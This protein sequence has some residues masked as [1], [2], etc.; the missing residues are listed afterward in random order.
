MGRAPTPISK[1]EAQEMRRQYENGATLHELR[2]EYGI[3]YD[4][5]KD[6]IV[7]AGGTIDRGRYRHLPNRYR[8]PDDVLI[9]ALER[10]VKGETVTAL[11]AEI[12]C[13]RNTMLNYLRYAR[14]L[15]VE[16]EVA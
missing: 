3:S 6:L 4:R 2:A 7:E 1:A 11:A 14:T 8:V 15:V 10:Y 5:V 13:A 9:D 16:E 12:G